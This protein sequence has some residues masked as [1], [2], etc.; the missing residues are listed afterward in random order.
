MP[1]AI[2]SASGPQPNQLPAI[3]KVTRDDAAARHACAYYNRTVPGTVSDFRPGTVGA[4]SHRLGF[5][6]GRGRYP[7][8]VPDSPGARPRPSPRFVPESAPDAPPSPAP[9]PT[10]GRWGPRTYELEIPGPQAYY[11]YV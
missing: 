2:T 6:R 4:L 9:S 8:R 7:V 5:V 1:V 3:I 11:Y 10:G